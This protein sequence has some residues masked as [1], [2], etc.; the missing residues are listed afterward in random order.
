M[1]ELDQH[2]HTPREAGHGQIDAGKRHRRQPIDCPFG[3]LRAQEAGNDA[4]GHDQRDGLGAES[5]LGGIGRSQ[6]EI[7]EERRLHALQ[8]G[9]E[10]HQRKAAL[11][12]RHAADDAAPTP[13]E[14]TERKA[15]APADH[16]HQQ[17]GRDGGAH[18]AE[19]DEEDRHRRQPFLVCAQQHVGRQRRRRDAH[20]LHRHEQR[21]R[22]HGSIATLRSSGGAVRRSKGKQRSSRLFWF[23]SLLLP[24]RGGIE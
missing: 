11:V 17:G 2:Q 22:Q 14:R 23:I 5:R 20:A 8:H 1:Q 12:H 21:L 9:R 13:E 16:R 19:M 7:P 3:S 15:R 6:T 10:A 18:D 24:G 4:A